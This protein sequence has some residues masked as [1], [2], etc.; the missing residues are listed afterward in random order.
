M[1][2]SGGMITPSPSKYC[3]S[4]NSGYGINSVIAHGSPDLYTLGGSVTS[5]MMVGLTNTDRLNFMTAVC[6]NTGEWDRGSTNGDCIAENMAFHAPNGFVGVCKNDKSGWIDVAELYNYSICFGLLGH[7]TAR[8]VTQSEANAYGKDFWN[9]SIGQGKWL[10]EAQE[11]N[12]FGAPAVPLWTDAIYVASV[13]RPGAVSIG[14]N[15]PV[16][17]TVTDGNYAPVESAMV[18][19][20]KAGETF[21]RGWTDASGQVVLYS[22]ALTPGFLD[23]TITGANNLPHVDS[24]PVMA[25]GRYV[26]YIGHVMSDTAGGNGDGVINPGEEIDI[27]TW[28]KNYGNQTAENVTGLLISSTPGVTVTDSLVSH[29]L[30][31]GL[32]RRQRLGLDVLLQPAR[33]RPGPVLRRLQPRRRRQHLAQRPARPGRDRGTHRHHRQRRHG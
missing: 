33:L 17:I 5:P 20:H 30:F 1:Y 29:R 8:R 13:T 10:M 24:I 3:D 9:G 27:Y 18:C 16:P 23:L 2:T 26:A 28:V 31:A 11:R 21:D 4:L 22:S 12:L 15:I 7:N 6:C 25:A 14:S 32:P 19:L